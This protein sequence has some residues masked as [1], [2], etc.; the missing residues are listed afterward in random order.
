MERKREMF[1]RTMAIFLTQLVQIGIYL[2]ALIFYAHLIPVLRSVGTAL[3]TGAS[4]V[5][6]VIG[7]A[8]Q[9]ALGNLIAGISLLL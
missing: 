4:I 8:A 9:N 5:S 7:L 1:D 3:L 6:I 2:M